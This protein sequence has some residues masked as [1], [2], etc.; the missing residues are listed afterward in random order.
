M[1]PNSIIPNMAK[2]AKRDTAKPKKSKSAYQFFCLE[3][4]ERV[5]NANPEAKNTEMFSLLSEQWK[6]CQG[7]DREKYIALA[8]QDKLRYKDEMAEYTPTPGFEKTSKRKKKGPKRPKNAYMLW[9]EDNRERIKDANPNVKHTEMFSLLSADWKQV[10]DAAKAPY[11]AK[12]EDL[13][14]KEQWAEDHADDS[15]SGDDTKRGKN[16]AGKKKKAKKDP[17]AP[18]RPPSAYQ[19]FSQAHR[20]RVVAENPDVKHTEYFKLLSQK[21]KAANEQE[22]APFVARANLLKAAHMAAKTQYDVQK[23]LEAAQ[24]AAESD[25]GSSSG[26]GS[27]V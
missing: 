11:E 6:Q 16:L 26:S 1:G 19:I 4:R 7:A 9:C 23:T 2:K 12:G 15:D 21:W 25:D 20:D 17:D 22:R 18:K 14:A 13:K 3:N 27:D 5:R 10:T 8:D 24:A